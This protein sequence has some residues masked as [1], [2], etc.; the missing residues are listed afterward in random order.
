[1]RIMLPLVTSATELRRALTICVSVRADLTAEGVA[2]DADVPIGVM[3]ETPSAA[4]TADLL[5]QQAQFLSIGTNDLIQYACAADRENVDVAHLRNPLQPAVL[6][7][8]KQAIDAATLAQVPISLCGDMAS[9]PSLT[10]LLLGLGL[11]DLSMEPHAIPMVKAIIRRSSMEESVAFAARAMASRSEEETA[12]L[13][14][15]AMAPK[16][17]SDLEA[18]LPA[19]DA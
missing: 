6:R 19:P 9:D 5:A 14:E 13:I 11:R 15:V 12:H 1:M 18:F 7:L 16:F 4:V 10:W 3:I 2:Y 8:L 17:A